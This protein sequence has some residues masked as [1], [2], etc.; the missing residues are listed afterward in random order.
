MAKKREQV[1]QEPEVATAVSAANIQQTFD[2]EPPKVEAL[3]VIVPPDLQ[4]SVDQLKA[5]LAEKDEMISALTD[6]P[7]QDQRRPYT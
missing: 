4:A 5:E 6:R 1:W 7:R 3:Q 2:I